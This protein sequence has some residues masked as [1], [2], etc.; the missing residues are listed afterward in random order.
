MFLL[1][2]SRVLLKKLAGSQLVREFPACYG[3]RSFITA[4]TRVRHLSLSWSRSIQPI[5]P[6]PTSRRT[7]VSVQVRGIFFL[8]FRNQIRFYGEEF[9]T[10][11]PTSNLE[12]HPLSAVRDYLFSIFTVTVHIGGRSSISNVKKR[13]AVVAGTNLYMSRFSCGNLK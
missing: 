9:L 12:D 7:K 8:I 6:H 4:F 11:R 3:T 10:P 5:P 2:W 1:S 13:Q